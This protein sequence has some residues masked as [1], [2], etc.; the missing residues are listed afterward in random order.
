MN[1][2]GDPQTLEP[3][4]LRSPPQV[5]EN[6]GGA[7]HPR[8][9]VRSLPPLSMMVEISGPRQTLEP[10]GPSAPPV[11][12]RNTG[13]ALLPRAMA[14]KSQLEVMVPISGPQPT[15]ELTG[16]RALPQRASQVKNCLAS[17]PRATARNLLSALR[18]E[19]SG[20][21]CQLHA[22]RPPPPRTAASATAL[23]LWRAD[24]RASPRATRGTQYLGRLHVV[25]E[26]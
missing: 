7:S 1:T 21:R 22:T 19:T 13:L 16:L 3:H 2:F 9:T 11:G 25:K 6:D 4:G 17:R 14:P 15:L 26:L 18:V 5:A 10:P 24:R 8:A 20:H 12:A 23:T